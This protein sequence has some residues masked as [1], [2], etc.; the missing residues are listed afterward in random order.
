MRF[1]FTMY[2][3]RTGGYR[4]KLTFVLKIDII[5]FSNI[6]SHYVHLGIFLE[7]REGCG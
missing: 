1:H 3:R 5:N 7:E 4:I 2:L 6:D